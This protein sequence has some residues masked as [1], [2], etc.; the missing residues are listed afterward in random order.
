MSRG[1]MTSARA[2][3]GSALRRMM[4]RF[5]AIFVLAGIFCLPSEAKEVVVTHNG[6]PQS[7]TYDYYVP[8][9][10]RGERLGVLVCTGGL[11]MDGDKYLRS[12]TRE[13][14]GSKWKDFA[15]EHHLLILGLGFLFMAEDWPNQESYQ[16]AQVWSGRA[17]DEVLK[18][19]EKELLIN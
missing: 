2:K 19:L 13:C 8:P 15:D 3:Q 16:Y 6:S 4:F 14:F 10:K 18:R 9:H 11:P 17:L 7:V 1:F 5:W 12:D